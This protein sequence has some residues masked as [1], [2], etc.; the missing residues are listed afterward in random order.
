MKCI[1]I[2]PRATEIEADM[3]II[4]FQHGNYFCVVFCSCLWFRSLFLHACFML[5]VCVCVHVFCACACVCACVYVCTR[6]RKDV[7]IYIC[8]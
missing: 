2:S 1:D 4:D 3:L 5:C 7:C 8:V 6:V